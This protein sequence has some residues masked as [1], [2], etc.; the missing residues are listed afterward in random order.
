MSI[1]SGLIGFLEGLAGTSPAAAKAKADVQAAEN[2]VLAAIEPLADDL[3]NA[4]LDRI[5]LVGGLLT[6]PADA[7]L[8][9]FLDKLLAKFEPA[10]NAPHAT[11]L[12]RV[13]PAAVVMQPVHSPG[14]P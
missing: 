10:A 6:G 9:S 8:N 3:L 14:D 13:A 1:F 11:A 5:P 4:V 2:S 12:A 7:M